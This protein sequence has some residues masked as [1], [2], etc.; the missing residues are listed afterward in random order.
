MVPLTGFMWLFRE[1]LP[2]LGFSY[3]IL[4]KWIITQNLPNYCKLNG[5]SKG[6]R[7][8]KHFFYCKNLVTIQKTLIWHLSRNNHKIVKII[9]QLL[10]AIGKKIKGS[11]KQLCQYIFWYFGKLWCMVI[12]TQYEKNSPLN[13]TIWQL[14]VWECVLYFLDRRRGKPVELRFN[15]T[16]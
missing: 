11:Y 4:W 14:S 7:K 3:F 9:Y 15:S 1:L 12:S 2:C 6:I 16:K 10:G 5:S 8:L 13:S